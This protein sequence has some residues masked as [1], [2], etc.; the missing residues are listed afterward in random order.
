MFVLDTAARKMT[1]VLAGAKATKDCPIFVGYLDST[2]G[3]TDDYGV[4]IVKTNGVTAVDLV[5][6][7]EAA[8]HR[9]IKMISLYNEDTAAVTAIFSY[10]GGPVTPVV[11][12]KFTLATLETLTYIEGQ[13]WVKNDVNGGRV[14]NA[15]AA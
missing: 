6:Q 3:Q 9:I 14:H 5:Q 8:K 1:V 10:V 7:A 12:A 2:P 11:V 13:G 15:T 4:N